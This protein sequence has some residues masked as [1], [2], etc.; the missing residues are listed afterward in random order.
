MLRTETVPRPVSGA[1]IH[2]PSHTL[3]SFSDGGM[4]HTA[5][6]FSAGTDTSGVREL[7]LLEL[8]HDLPFTADGTPKH[9]SFEDDTHNLILS[10]RLIRPTSQN[11]AEASDLVAA[12]RPAQG[13]PLPLSDR[14]AG[15]N[16]PRLRHVGARR[17]RPDTQFRQ[18]SAVE[19]DRPKECSADLLWPVPAP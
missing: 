15:V 17:L 7:G 19:D 5:P 10:A 13:P 11:S 4:L 16:G 2:C 14:P 1:T 6:T 12:Y 8:V 18:S 9:S 3:P